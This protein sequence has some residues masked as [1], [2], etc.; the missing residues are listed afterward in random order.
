[1]KVKTKSDKQ[2]V[3]MLVEDE[4]LE[5]KM[6]KDSVGKW[7]IGIGRNLQ[8]NGITKEE[9]EFLFDNDLKRVKQESLA[10]IPDLLDHPTGIELAVY[11]LM[12]NMG[13]TRLRKF[14]KFLA[15]LEKRDYNE[16]CYELVNSKWYR[17]KSV[18]SKRKFRILMMVA[19]AG[20]SDVSHEQWLKA[21]LSELITAYNDWAGEYYTGE[22]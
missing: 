5:L 6:Y 18:G 10:L 17:E 15:A 19:Y 4:G 21:P 9:A 22:P 14:V 12:F 7:S 11:N 8:D 20:E 16:A 13:Y 1:M 2:I 3:D